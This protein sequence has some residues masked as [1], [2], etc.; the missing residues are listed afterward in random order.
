MCLDSFMLIPEKHG[1][2]VLL[3]LLLH[4]ILLPN[5][6]LHFF[7]KFYCFL[8]FLKQW[9]AGASYPTCSELKFI[10]GFTVNR[11]SDYIRGTILLIIIYILKKIILILN[12]PQNSSPMVKKYTKVSNEQ[13]KELVR[14]IYEEQ[15]S[16]AKAAELTQI[17][18][19]TAKAINKVY[20]NE[21]RI[22]KRVCRYRAKKEDK[23]EGV[24]RNKIDVE[25]IASTPLTEKAR[26][27]ITC[28]VKLLLKKSNLINIKSAD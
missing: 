28:G 17:Y 21:Q 4:N 13:R 7:R 3:L 6:P 11:H 8:W 26:F 15:C 23:Q 16:I 19:P 24:I 14:L 2:V 5:G 22:Q 18:Y 27:R 20:K 9:L 10:R 1:F 25:R 12:Y